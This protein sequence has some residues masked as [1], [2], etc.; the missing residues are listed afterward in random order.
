MCVDGFVFISLVLL[1][2]ESP[3]CRTS[4]CLCLAPSTLVILKDKST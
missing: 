1:E 2:I 4:M 3:G